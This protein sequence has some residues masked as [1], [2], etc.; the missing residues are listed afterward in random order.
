M[1]YILDTSALRGM[2]IS[3]AQKAGKSFNTWVPTLAVLEVADDFKREMTDTEF[4]RQK[5]NIAKVKFLKGIIDDPFVILRDRGTISSINEGKRDDK[6]LLMRLIES[7]S[8]VRS[9]DALYNLPIKEDDYRP[10]NWGILEKLKKEIDKEKREYTERIRSMWNNNKLSFQNNPDRI[11]TAEIYFSALDSFVKQSNLK[12]IARNKYESDFAIH[13]GYIVYCLVKYRMNLKLG[14]D[15]PDISQLDGND[16]FDG[17]ILL[18]LS[19]RKTDTL[20]L[21]DVKTI[22]AIERTLQII[23]L[24]D[25]KFS[26]IT[27]KEFY[28]TTDEFK[29]KVEQI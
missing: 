8:C 23:R 27:N 10:L 26:R 28:I 22:S 16:Y 7:I 25:R 2:S 14:A 6:R 1:A 21:G 4:R 18:Y 20:V 11:M 12:G 24:S 13:L 5:S 3:N 15:I 19:L 29:K 9:V 17:M